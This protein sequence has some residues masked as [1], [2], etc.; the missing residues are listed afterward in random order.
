MSNEDYEFRAWYES[1]TGGTML[2]VGDDYG[3]THPLD[4]CSYLM[5]KQPV[6]LM[7]YTGFKDLKGTKIF[8]QDIVSGYIHLNREIDIGSRHITG[9]VEKE[10][11]QYTV[12]CLDKTGMYS[13]A[14]LE[15]I[16]VISNTYKDKDKDR[17]TKLVHI[18]INNKTL[19]EIY[20]YLTELQMAGLINEDTIV[21][22]IE[23]EFN[24]S[25]NLSNKVWKAWNIEFM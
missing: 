18:Y 23:E 24:L 15:D 7:Q 20:G 8:E 3:T 21:K 4:C 1:P 9:V 13:L 11:G 25:K 2:Q 22:H 19:M 16:D 12:T 5:G 10:L 6:I 17:H 14:L